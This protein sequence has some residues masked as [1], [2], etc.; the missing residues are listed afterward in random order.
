MTISIGKNTRFNISVAD[1]W[2]RKYISFLSHFSSLLFFR[3]LY[4]ENRCADFHDLFPSSLAQPINRI[5]YQLVKDAI[6]R[7]DR[8]VMD[9]Q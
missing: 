2:M 7:A 9:N 1:R 4:N 5:C 6:N 3:E 8:A